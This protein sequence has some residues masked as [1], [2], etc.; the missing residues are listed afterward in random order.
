MDIA[1]QGTNAR[2]PSTAREDAIALNLLEN[3]DAPTRMKKA[4]V[5]AATRKVPKL[6]A[7]NQADE[8]FLAGFEERFRAINQSINIYFGMFT[9]ILEVFT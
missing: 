5:M 4:R 2:Q 9:I 1:S 8:T 6:L 3:I 7:K